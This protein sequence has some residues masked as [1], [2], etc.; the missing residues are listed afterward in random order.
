MILT[1]ALVVCIYFFLSQS[2]YCEEYTRFESF[3]PQY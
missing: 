3:S 2:R 1:V